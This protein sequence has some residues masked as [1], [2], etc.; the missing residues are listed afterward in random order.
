MGKEQ[1][2]LDAARNGNV[3]A[4]ERLVGGKGKR[5]GLTALSLSSL[6]R[7]VN[8]NCCDANGDTPLHLAALAGH[9]EAVQLLLHHEASPNISD[10]KGCTALH[11]AAWTG[12][13]EVCHLLLTQGSVPAQVNNQNSDGDTALHCA[14][15][16]G[17]YKAVA[18]LAEGQADPMI[19]NLK[20]ES[21]LDLAAQYGRDEVVQLLM[22]K[23]PSLAFHVHQKHSPLHLASRFGH[24]AVVQ[25]L[26]NTGFEIGL[27]TSH[28]TALHEA[29]C[30]C[31]ADAIRLLLDKGIPVSEKDSQGK[32]AIDILTAL[33]TQ[34]ALD[35][36]TLIKDY[37]KKSEAAQGHGEASQP[38]EV[39][40][41]PNSSSTGTDLHSSIKAEES[42]HSS[43]T[44]KGSHSNP[45]E[46]GSNSSVAI[47]G[48]EVTPLS[49]G[50]QVHV[51][52]LTTE[53]EYDSPVG[54]SVP[55]AN[56]ETTSPIYAKPNKQK[57]AGEPPS[58]PAPPLPPRNS[59]MR[60]PPG[61]PPKGTELTV[62]RGTR[63][64]SP[65]YMEMGNRSSDALAKTPG[66]PPRKKGPRADQSSTHFRSYAEADQSE[67]QTVIA[68]E[69]ICQTESAPVHTQ[70]TTQPAEDG[71]VYEQMNRVSDVSNKCDKTEDSHGSLSPH[72]DTLYGNLLQAADKTLSNIQQTLE[73][74]DVD[75]TNDSKENIPPVVQ[76]GDSKDRGEKGTG[77]ETVSPGG[78][79]GTDYKGDKSECSSVT[80]EK[81]PVNMRN[82]KSSTSSEETRDS[83]GS[84][85]DSR[86]PSLEFD[87]VR[88]RL[89]SQE[90]PLTPTGYSQPPTPDHPPPSPH[91]AVLGIHERINPMDKR[92]S[93]DI[94]TLT[95]PSLL[96]GI[97]ER[98]PEMEESEQETESQSEETPSKPEPKEGRDGA[99]LPEQGSSTTSS[100]HTSPVTTYT[101][102]SSVMTSSSTSTSTS[103]TVSSRSQTSSSPS[104]STSQTT[105]TTS[106]SNTVTGDTSVVTMDR[107]KDSQMDTDSGVPNKG[108]VDSGSAETLPNGVHV[109]M[110]RKSRTPSSSS[111]S[112][113]KQSGGSS[114][115]SINTVSDKDMEPFS[116]LLRGSQ[117]GG[118]RNVVSQIYQNVVIRR[119]K[120]RF[121]RRSAPSAIVA[122]DPLMER[123]DEINADKFMEAIDQAIA[124]GAASGETTEPVE[125]ANFDDSE[126]WAK[127]SAIL[128]S[129]GGRLSM[130]N[131]D[132]VYFEKQMTEILSCTDTGK[133]LSVGD[134][135]EGLGLGRYENTLVANGFDDLDFIGGTILE[136]EDLKTI[137]VENEDHRRRIRE[138][139]RLLLP[140]VP[141]GPTHMPSSVE[142]WLSS[143][144]LSEYTDAFK[145]HG[146]T[147]MDRVRK[148]WEL[149]L[150]TVLDITTLGHRKRLLASLGERQIEKTE[151]LQ[152]DVTEWKNSGLNDESPVSKPQPSPIEGLDF[153]KD[154][155]KVK[156]KPREAA[157]DTS[158]SSQNSIS[159]VDSSEE[160]DSLKR[161]GRSLRDSTIH[162]R[163]PHMAHTTS[164]VTQWRHRPEKLIKGCCNY[165]AQY[166]GSTLVKELHGI[167]STRE[168]M[169]KMKLKFRKKF[170]NSADALGKIPVIM[171]SISYK[172]VKFIDAKTKRVVCEHE[173]GNIFCAC[174]DP[175]N[176]NFF[177]YI[178]KDRE[179]SKHYCHVFSV[180]RTDLAREIILTLGEAFEI[181]YQV[182]LKEKAEEEALE[183]EKKLG[184]G[185]DAEDSAS[186]S[187][188]TSLNTI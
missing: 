135:L 147:S 89:L 86:P 93:R 13:A 166:L 58:S 107:H 133:I 46:V 23:H 144:R 88:C 161:S 121:K 155:T 104:T 31:K 98:D 153:Y 67:K 95:E 41:G 53:P 11:M 118:S 16:Y 35:M 145:S 45:P 74:T 64:T 85:R 163:P 17:H 128:N 28:G 179:T 91:T 6:R 19:R 78:Q 25:R 32:T 3:V 165:V 22:T 140:V 72:E 43:G 10:E 101:T 136:E 33:N 4:I 21:P 63:E 30:Y 44:Q 149:E 105:S 138:A 137:G 159:Q 24:V 108:A 20:E 113:E 57:A 112:T 134:W 96:G 120:S 185:S 79:T 181:A 127:I 69:S 110:R 158:A 15:Q 39:K 175:E 1:D 139:S 82:N 109:V 56:T 154:Y 83:V 187:S 124:E 129:Y 2:L 34:I 150:A 152:V 97:P 146:Y 171:L 48:K 173:I 184:Q 99:P 160:E 80:S 186:H 71:T 115:D 169:T 94:E 162:I 90:I 180:S 157:A 29:C 38:E 119:P 47:A 37:L 81:Q 87:N 66:K 122:F 12:S 36:I 156:P 123:E 126:E 60:T 40:K 51:E 151:K 76:S 114:S 7:T 143:L 8:V 125:E 54:V 65:S 117:P 42:L 100:P 55:P 49:S 132:S 102:S 130:A 172:G 68:S 26:L 116:G 50:L 52:D 59:S 62:M 170:Q 92:K 14:A 5:G 178:T 111:D 106:P 84:G 131:T 73:K 61:S 141:I 176:L 183:F 188:K 174:Q 77:E 9:K 148:L 18:A 182:A 168:G 70:H 167:D 103:S 164:P 177:A 75:T 142:N 27:K